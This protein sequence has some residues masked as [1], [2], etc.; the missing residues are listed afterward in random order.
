MIETARLVLRPWRDE[1]VA[2]FHAVNQDAEV[3]RFLYDDPPDLAAMRASVDRRRA[4]QARHG[5]CFWAV[6]R[7]DTGALIGFCGL[8]HGPE[9][10]P[11]AGEVEIGWRLARPH[12]RQGFAH[13]AASASLAWAWAAGMPEVVAVT[14]PANEPSWRLME[15]LGMTR[16]AR[17][18]F[19]HPAIPAGHRLSR[20]LTYRIQRPA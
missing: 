6:E 10:T 13:E 12:W 16:D 11:V 9:G 1:D 2:P 4:S 18:D 20:H 3:I 8:E 15:K 7:R 19:D 5:H 17:A 14:T